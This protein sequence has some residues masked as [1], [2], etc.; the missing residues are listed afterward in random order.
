MKDLFNSKVV[1]QNFAA[2]A[3]L[4]EGNCTEVKFTH[5]TSSVLNMSYFDIFHELNICTDNG[6][7]RQDF[8]E[9][10]ED[11]NLGDKLRKAML[12]EDCEDDADIEAYDTLH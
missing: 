1:T 6:Y 8:E 2:L 3:G 12:W 4:G 11:I 5:M 10:Y 9:V 7:I